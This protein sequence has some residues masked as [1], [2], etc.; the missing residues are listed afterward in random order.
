MRPNCLGG[1]IIFCRLAEVAGWSKPSKCKHENEFVFPLKF[2]NSKTKTEETLYKRT[3]VAPHQEVHCGL[4]RCQ[5]KSNWGVIAH[6]HVW[7]RRD[8]YVSMGPLVCSLVSTGVFMC[9]L[10]LAPVQAQCTRRHYVDDDN[11]NNENFLVAMVGHLRDTVDQ[12]RQDQ[13][14]STKQL[15]Q[16]F[17]HT[18]EQ[19]RQDQQRSKEQQRQDHQRSKEQQ[20]QDH[21]RSKEQQRQDH[22]RSMDQQRQDHQRSKEQLLQLFN[23]SMVEQQKQLTRLEKRLTNVCM[24]Y[25]MINTD[26]NNR[27]WHRAN[28][29]FHARMKNI[30]WLNHIFAVERYMSPLNTLSISIHDSCNPWSTQF[31]R[32]LSLIYAEKHEIISH[33]ILPNQLSICS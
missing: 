15:Q 28:C 11:E 33:N 22:Q 10:H 2:A 20:R 29:F 25:L 23:H 12:L 21:Q 8:N 7:R 4:L 9:V 18:V 3:Q 13:Q 19:L 32:L 17:N 26:I 5:H 6:T 31:G 1:V 24:Y 16:Q 14:H 30:N 27:Y